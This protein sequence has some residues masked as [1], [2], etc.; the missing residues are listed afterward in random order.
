MLVHYPIDPLFIVI[1][2]ILALI[3]VSAI[4]EVSCTD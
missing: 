4:G 3:P 1:P 2:L